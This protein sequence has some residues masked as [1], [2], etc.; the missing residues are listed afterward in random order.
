[1]TLNAFAALISGTDV[2][3]SIFM[4]LALD[5]VAVGNQYLW[6]AGSSSDS[7][8]LH[9]H[10][11]TTNNNNVQRR[12]NGGGS[13][14]T[15]TSGTL[16]LN[17]MVITHSF[18]GTGARTTVT[19]SGGFSVRHDPGA[20]DVGLCTFNRFAIGGLLRSTFSG[21]MNGQCRRFAGKLSTFSA[22]DELALSARFGT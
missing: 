5:T 7:D 11:A 4:Q 6:S 12:D 13:I 17:E 9:S 22:A 18:N 10:N 21:G 14:I 1:L 19:T 8:P 16:G 2:A 15:A 20:L 3:F